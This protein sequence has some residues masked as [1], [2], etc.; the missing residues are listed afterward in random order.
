MLRPVRFSFGAREGCGGGI[1]SWAWNARSGRAADALRP[2]PVAES[3]RARAESIGPIARAGEQCTKRGIALTLDS[4]H[5][6]RLV[7][8]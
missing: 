5:T 6:Y 8:S 4:L 3:V 1:L 2:A 7:V